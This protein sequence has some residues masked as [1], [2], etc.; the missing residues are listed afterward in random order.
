V[1][2]VLSK[3]L[4]IVF[5][6]LAWVLA[7]CLWAGFGRSREARRAPLVAVLILYAASLWPVANGL[8]RYLESGAERTMRPGTIYDAVVLLGGAVDHEATAT[9]GV[10]SYNGGVERLL[11][12]YDLLRT[13]RA[14]HVIV[15]GGKS[16]PDD[17]VIEARVLGEQLVDW[18]IEPSRVIL[19][20][21]A[22]NTREN[23]ERSKLLLDQ[24]GFRS[25]LVVTSA[26][27]MARAMG[28]FRASGV[29]ADA[30]PVDYRASNRPMSLQPSAG[31]L[32]QT[33]HTLRELAG[34]AVYRILGYSKG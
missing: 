24:N 5:T 2:Y 7:L 9:S 28:C 1:F 11:V 30:L 26:F 25:V 20:E 4:D 34:R 3:L 6:P 27:H 14:K 23:A 10:P 31:A 12:T 29:A 15:S 17:P 21:S 19:D 33:T 8:E 13:G 22:R 16:V 18:G 32:E